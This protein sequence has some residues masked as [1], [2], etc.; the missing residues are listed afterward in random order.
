MS[1]AKNYLWDDR[2]PA[3]FKSGD[4]AA[5]IATEHY[6]LTIDEVT[7]RRWRQLMGLMREVDTWSDEYATPAEEVLAGLASFEDFAPLYPALA[8]SELSTAAQAAIL[9]RTAKILR[10]G[11]HATATDSVQ[12]FVA[13]RAAEARETVNLFSDV[14]TE[15]VSGQPK[16]Q[17]EFLPA[18][19]ALGEAATL[20]DSIV[21]G[22]K[23]WRYGKQVLKPHP[24]YYVQLSRA[25]ARRGRLGGVALLH[26]RP[27]FHMAVKGGLRVMNRVQHGVPSYSNLRIFDRPQ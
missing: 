22:K 7:T 8:P 25:I 20:W 3:Y 11:A 17:E 23:D 5:A 14:A 18:L 13:M 24:E 15:A 16:F 12:R 1:E 9:G 2:A 19:R 10:L 4:L 26:V 21:D 6:G 27:L